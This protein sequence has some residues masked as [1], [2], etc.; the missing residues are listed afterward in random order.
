MECQVCGGKITPIDTEHI[1]IMQCAGCKGF[2][3]KKGDLN[4][5]IK[6][7]AGDLEFSSIDHHMH[8]DTHGIMK[9]IYC[10]DS[11]MIKI[12]F[13][14]YSDIIMDYCPECGAFW[15]D[16]GEMEKMQEYVDTIEKSDK[17]KTIIETIMNTIFSLPKF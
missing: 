3:I 11:A 7:K 13:I 9:C 8:Q 4:N 17:K 14:E 10:P 15:I 6:H 12:N 5:L 1:R 2:W 16:R